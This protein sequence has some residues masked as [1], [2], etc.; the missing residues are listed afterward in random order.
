MKVTIAI[1][2]FITV[3]NFFGFKNRQIR[4]DPKAWIANTWASAKGIL[5]RFKNHQ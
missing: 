2:I 3:I 4:R 5:V 1:V